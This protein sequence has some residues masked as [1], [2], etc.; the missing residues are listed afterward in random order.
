MSDVYKQLAAK[1]DSLP[2]GFPATESGVE[3]KILKKIFS[4]EDAEIALK[5]RPIPE[6]AAAI[7]E[8]L[9][10]PVEEMEVILDNM[11]KKGQ[12]G[13]TRMQG[14]QVFM[15]FPFVFG[16][17]EFQQP[18]IDKELAELVEDRKSVV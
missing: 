9:G 6:T 11:V 14:Q 10:K 15:L 18:R 5:I 16:I 1:L 4:P 17:Y 2:N 12:I 8:R 7:A 13:S 3:I